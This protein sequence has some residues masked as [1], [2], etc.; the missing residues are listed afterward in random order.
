MQNVLLMLIFFADITIAE[1]HSNL[2]CQLQTR[3]GPR[4][5]HHC[6]EDF[7]YPQLSII[8]M[9]S[10]PVVTNTLMKWTLAGVIKAVR[11]LRE[12]DG[13]KPA[14]CYGTKHTR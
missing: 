8:F 11:S 14:V 9:S 13:F 6:T 5:L 10:K 7:F 4:F 12:R 1:L 2:E 3:E